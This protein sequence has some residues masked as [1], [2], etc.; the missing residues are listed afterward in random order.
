MIEIRQAS[1]SFGTYKAVNKVTLDI[2]PGSI[3]GLLGSNGAGKT[4]LLKLLAAI[5]N[6]DSGVI[7]YNG[8]SIFENLNYKSE[9]IFIA[10]IPYFFKNVNLKEMATFYKETFPSFSMKRF[11]Q[12]TELLNINPLVRITKL[13]KGMKRQC[14]FI[15]AISARPKIMLLDEPFDGLDP[16]VRHTIKNILIQDVSNYQTALFVSSHNLREMEDFCDSISIMHKGEVL[17]ARELD[18][19]KSDV[20]KLQMAFKELPLETF[21]K[22]FNILEKNEKGRVVTCIVRGNFDNIEQTI[23]A[24]HPLMYDIL[25]LSL[26]EIFTYELGGYGYAIENIIVE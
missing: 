18:D 1:K 13:S 11:N 22:N 12:L 2:K 5:Y 19:L 20:C 8:K 9:M 14:A 21:Y 3:H 24:A 15:L 17:L 25:P 23:T 16:I 10:D 6:T 4:T 26:E 7:H